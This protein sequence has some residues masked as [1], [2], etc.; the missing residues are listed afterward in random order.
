M[1]LS[2]VLC[3]VCVATLA[4]ARA[5]VR[6]GAPYYA[7]LAEPA[8]VG[9]APPVLPPSEWW[10]LW[11]SQALPGVTEAAAVVDDNTMY[12][13]GGSTH[14]GL[15]NGVYAFVEGRCATALRLAPDAQPRVNATLP[16]PNGAVL[17]RV[18]A[19]A[20]TRPAHRMA[21]PQH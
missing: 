8:P 6:S 3:V 9:D 15:T 7:S 19:Y 4:V 21:P 14:D 17:S 18:R 13:F 12:I 2:R 16:A 11:P 5:G 1:H 10:T 20:L